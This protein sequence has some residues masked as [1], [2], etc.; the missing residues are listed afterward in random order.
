[1]LRNLNLQ[2]LMDHILILVG[3]ARCQ[4][5]WKEGV[6]WQVGQFAD[7]H[8]NFFPVGVPSFSFLP[9]GD[10][11]TVCLLSIKIWDSLSMVL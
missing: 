9:P 4:L 3:A 1:L 5:V 2:K 11:V 8:L 7:T 10:L 6:P